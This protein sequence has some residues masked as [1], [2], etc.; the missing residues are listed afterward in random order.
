[1]FRKNVSKV[2]AL[3]TDKAA[4]PINLYGATK[5]TSDKLLHQQIFLKEK[6]CQFSV[7]R[8]GNVMGSRGSV[9]P[10]FLKQNKT[11][12]YFTVTDRNMTR[13]NITLEESV[14]FVL[15]CISIMKGEK[16][17]FLKCPHIK[18]LMLLNQLIKI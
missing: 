9:I 2:V 16:C 10:L 3:S 14:K 6:K 5:L 15:K 8:Y 4:A 12:N 17:L 11:Q 1:M 13:F 18:Y 7:V